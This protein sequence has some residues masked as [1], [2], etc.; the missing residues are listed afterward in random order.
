M[1]RA[2]RKRKSGIKREKNG[3]ALRTLETRYDRGTERAQA[4][5]ALYGPDGADAI[6][7]A[8]RAGLL[9]EGS[10]AKAILD[11]ARSISNAYWQA[12]ETGAITCTLGD[13][14]GGSVTSID[15]ARVKR[16]EEWLGECLAIVNAMGRDVRHAFDQ[17]VI[18]VH[19][20]HGPLFLDRL[21]F[22]ARSATIEA[23]EMDKRMMRAA[24]DAL[25][26][27]TS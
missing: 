13:R 14:T 25:E 4:M 10:E 16:R 7:R 3:R 18:N 11:M 8:F 12:F 2:G 21:C 23:E 1:A 5:Q 27:L 26:T 22:A 24:L 20:D 9:G 6:G 15:H 19:P 17:L